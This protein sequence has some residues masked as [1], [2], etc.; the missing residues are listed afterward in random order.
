MGIFSAIANLAAAIIPQ[1]PKEEIEEGWIDTEADQEVSTR[2]TPSLEDDWIDLG[3][4][5]AEGPPTS[6][7]DDPYITEMT[8]TV[9]SLYKAEFG[10]RGIEVHSANKEVLMKI[11]KI[12]SLNFEQCEQQLLTALAQ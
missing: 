12:V 11:C 2:E 9:I 5:V 8:T 4:A 10:R 1:E 7:N 6:I 3:D